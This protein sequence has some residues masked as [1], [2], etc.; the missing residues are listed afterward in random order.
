ML[1]RVKVNKDNKNAN[2]GKQARF[3]LNRMN[4]MINGKIVDKEYI[5]RL[6]GENNY[7]IP[8]GSEDYRLF[9]K[10]VFTGMFEYAKAE[11]PNNRI[12]EKLVIN[13]NQA[14]YEFA[15]YE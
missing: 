6:Y 14:G 5:I 9:A 1:S 8:N 15:I 10:R 3:D 12:L 2:S 11:V 4:F 13:C 7:L